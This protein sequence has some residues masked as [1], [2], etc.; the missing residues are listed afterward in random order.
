M[1][2]PA[3]SINVDNKIRNNTAPQKP[4][5]KDGHG[6]AKKKRIE[7]LNS[8]PAGLLERTQGSFLEED[9]ILEQIQCGL[10][11]ES[12]CLKELSSSFVTEKE[13][14]RSKGE[15]LL[16][17]THHKDV[18][19]DPNKS[20]IQWNCGKEMTVNGSQWM[21]NNGMGKKVIDSTCESNNK[22][23]ATVIGQNEKLLIRLPFVDWMT[24]LVKA[25]NNLNGT[26]ENGEF[27]RVVSRIVNGWLLVLAKLHRSE[28]STS[29]NN[30][31]GTN[32]CLG[33]VSNLCS[34]EGAKTMPDMSVR[35]LST[36]RSPASEPLSSVVFSLATSYRSQ[37]YRRLLLLLLGYISSSS[38][39]QV[40]RSH[41]SSTDKVQTCKV[42]SSKASRK[43]VQHARELACK[44]LKEEGTIM[45]KQ[46]TPLVNLAS[47]DSTSFHPS[48][49]SH[50]KARSMIEAESMYSYCCFT[51]IA[52][53]CCEYLGNL[54]TAL[55]AYK[56][57]RAI[58]DRQRQRQND[59][60]YI[61]NKSVFSIYAHFDQILEGTKNET[62]AD[63][64]VLEQC[65]LPTTFAKSN[66]VIDASGS[67][68]MNIT[69]TPANTPNTM[70][71]KKHANDNGI[72]NIHFGTMFH[73]NIPSIKK[74]LSSSFPSIDN[75]TVSPGTSPFRGVDL[76]TDG[77]ISFT[78]KR[79][80]INS[81]IG[82]DLIPSGT[83]EE[84]IRRCSL[85]L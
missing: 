11:V 22:E 23:N 58:Q 74:N 39:S 71:R 78:T 66:H 25:R 53:E 61:G 45:K 60:G 46:I 5:E 77:A 3:L 54:D 42:L 31:L 50:L 57:I 27:E 70:A 9:T 14:D 34:L 68:R 65:V 32:K 16:C 7:G 63:G 13:N 48:F 18:T 24:T 21:S 73:E 72:T 30:E 55:L 51:A 1:I 37:I 35:V 26:N 41:Y 84:R 85:E 20:K 76:V 2:R 67:P 56:S 64:C 75:P 36:S 62:G 4:N 38:P 15:V 52:A 82:N 49:S 69:K 6:D 43:V 19:F 12:K 44:I 47:T 8:T 28:Q 10:V 40:R 79:S 80:S 29:Y 33:N 59:A 17:T 83:L 81:K